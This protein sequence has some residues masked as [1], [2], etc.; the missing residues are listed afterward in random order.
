MEANKRPT[1]RLRPDVG[2]ATTVDGLVLVLLPQHD[3]SN[4]PTAVQQHHAALVV[5]HVSSAVAWG[6]M[7]RVSRVSYSTTG[8]IDKRVVRQRTGSESRMRHAFL[9]AY[10]S[11]FGW[12]CWIEGDVCY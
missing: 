10:H 9:C 3:D 7:D 1:E 6:V 2:P 5:T 11:I 4:D 12:C 8:Q